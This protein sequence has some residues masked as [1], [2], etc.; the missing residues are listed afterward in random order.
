MDAMSASPLLT[1]SD[2]AQI[3]GVSTSTVGRL[4]KLGLLPSFD[5]GSGTRRAKNRVRAADLE[6]FIASRSKGVSG[7]SK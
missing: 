4:F 1:P 3:L 7:V 6:A 2:I 5:A